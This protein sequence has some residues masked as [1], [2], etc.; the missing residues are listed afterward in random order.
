MVESRPYR[1]PRRPA[2]ARAELLAAAGTQFDAQCAR[3]AYRL[4]AT[5]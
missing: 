3:A 4:V 2:G 1:P 5:G